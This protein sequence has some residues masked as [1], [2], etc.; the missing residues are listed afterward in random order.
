M[1]WHLENPWWHFVVRGVI[2]YGF[3]FLLLRLIGKRQIGELSPFDLVLLLIISDAVQ[4][5]MNAG[6]NS[7]TA[8]LI[9]AGTLISVNLL[10]NNL[11]FRYR[12][13]ERWVDGSPVI[14]VHNGKLYEQAL[15]GEKVTRQ[16]L[17]TALHQEG[18]ADLADVQFAI[19]EPN[20][21]ITVMK[22]RDADV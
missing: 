14:L 20:G 6:D 11:M 12:K 8:G 3:V 9:L 15:R 18:I 10:V 7:I 19:L 1:M 22:K 21:Q 5:A 4:N 16:D 2:V 13:F 17:N